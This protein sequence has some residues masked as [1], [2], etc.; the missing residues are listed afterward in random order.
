MGRGSTWEPTREQ[1]TSFGGR[2]SQRTKLMKDYVK[3]LYKTISEN[4][5][6][7]PEE[8]HYDYFK[9]K[10]GELY[11]RGMKKPLTT[12]GVLKS[13]GMLAD[14]LG[15][16]GL[17]NLGFDIPRGKV[18]A[19]QAVMLNKAAEELPPESD[20][21]RV[22]DIEL[23]EIAEKATKSTEDLIS[24]LNDQQSQTDDLFEHPLRELLGLDTQLR[25]IRGSLKVE[26]AKNLELEECIAKE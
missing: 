13:V 4:I 8:F 18:T 19:R 14:I 26:V 21:T 16:G 10:G 12:K 9:L 1:E 22:D 24:H 3:D 7:T 23:Q 17:R 11:Y 5:G 2:E 15:K 6:E 25:S 20:I